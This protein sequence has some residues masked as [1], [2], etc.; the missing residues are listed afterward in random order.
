MKIDVVKV[1]KVT[2]MILTIAGT[3]ASGWVGTK[4]NEKVLEKLVDE[5][6]KQ[7]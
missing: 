3:L 7:E 5:R 6:L 4:E 1:V 2:G